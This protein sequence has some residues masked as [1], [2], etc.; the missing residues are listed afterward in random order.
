MITVM[1]MTRHVSMDAWRLLWDHNS[2]LSS[3]NNSMLLFPAGTL[4]DLAFTS[5]LIYLTIS[6]PTPPDWVGKEEQKNGRPGYAGTSG[7][8]GIGGVDRDSYRKT[9][10]PSIARWSPLSASLLIRQWLRLSRDRELV[11]TCFSMA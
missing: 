4:L 7:R 10:N 6:H 5:Y 1:T 8:W 2:L 11:S 9:T 3:L